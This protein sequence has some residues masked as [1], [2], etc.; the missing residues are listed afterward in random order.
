MQPFEVHRADAVM[1]RLLDRWVVPDGTEA[2][3]VD[4]TIG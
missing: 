1:E 2:H 4:W 3:H